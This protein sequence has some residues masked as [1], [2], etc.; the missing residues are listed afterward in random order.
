MWRQ[1]LYGRGS[2]VF[3]IGQIL[4]SSRE[5]M[6]G[7]GWPGCGCAGPCSSLWYSIEWYSSACLITHMPRLFGLLPR[8]DLI[9]FFVSLK[10]Q[11]HIPPPPRTCPQLLLLFHDGACCPPPPPGVRTSTDDQ[12][13][14]SNDLRI[15][16]RAT[17]ASSA[18]RALFGVPTCLHRR[19]HACPRGLLLLLM[20][21]VR[22]QCGAAV[23]HATNAAAGSCRHGCWCMLVRVG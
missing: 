19:W 3:G 13:H 7:R 10:S 1:K 5:G 18:E 4:V 15:S 6:A 12:F 11:T 14:A 16:L 8:S 22:R 21:Q 20:R 9:I 2:D 23:P 17:C